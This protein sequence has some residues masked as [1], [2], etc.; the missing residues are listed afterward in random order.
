MD[1]DAPAQGHDHHLQPRKSLNS[2]EEPQG[3]K[4][5]AFAERG[6][7][8]LSVISD[9]GRRAITPNSQMDPC[10]PETLALGKAC[11]HFLN[12]D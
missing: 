10:K 6:Q 12:R 7:G 2:Q 9:T 5:M 3:S 4:L 1:T 11:D 8:N